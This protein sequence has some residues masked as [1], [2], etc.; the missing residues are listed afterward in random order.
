VE[1]TPRRVATSE[2]V[3]VLVI[4][5]LRASPGRQ[6][7]AGREVHVVLAKNQALPRLT[8]GRIRLRPCGA[9]LPDGLEA[10][11]ARPAVAGR[12]AMVVWMSYGL[13]IEPANGCLER[14]PGVEAGRARRPEGQR[15]CLA[16]GFVQT[17]KGGKQ[18]VEVRPSHAD[19]PEGG[20]LQFATERA[21]RQGLEE[22]ILCGSCVNLFTRHGASVTSKRCELLL[23]F[24]RR[25]NNWRRGYVSNVQRWL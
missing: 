4:V 3:I 11:S 15:F 23:Q 9:R 18:E 25:S 17:G 7:R 16:C 14:E 5:V 20:G 1:L 21:V 19:H 13:A 24:D 2:M 8:Q 22:G 12:W 10:G 6:N